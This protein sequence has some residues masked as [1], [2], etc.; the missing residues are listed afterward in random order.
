MDMV[1]FEGA[2]TRQVDDKCFWAALESNETALLLAGSSS[3]AIGAQVTAPRSS[4]SPSVDPIAAIEAAFSKT[5]GVSALDLSLS[6]RFSYAW[7]AL[8]SD[9][10]ESGMTLPRVEGIAVFATSLN[11]DP[12]RCGEYKEQA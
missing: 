8:M 2:A 7:Q 9:A 5:D 12:R 11:T 1:S 4:I 3:Y 6:Q 10:V